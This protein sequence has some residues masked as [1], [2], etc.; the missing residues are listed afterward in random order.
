MDAARGGG[1]WGVPLKI[2]V[3]KNF[4]WRHL[5]FEH[6]TNVVGLRADEPDRV[7]KIRLR[8][9]SYP[10]RWE[11]ETPML[12]AGHDV[13]H[14]TEFWANNRQGFDLGLAHYQGNCDLCFLKS[15]AKKIQQIRDDPSSADWWVEQERKTGKPFRPGMPVERL[16]QARVAPTEERRE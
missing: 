9:E 15:K 16:I 1:A 4:M 2:L 12:T 14:V 13:G 10:E 6:W 11:V 7:A 5:G 8:Q 3:I